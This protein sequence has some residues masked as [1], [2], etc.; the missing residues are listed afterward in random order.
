MLCDQAQRHPFLLFVHPPRT[1]VRSLS[2]LSKECEPCLP[3]PLCRLGAVF[4]VN[5]WHTTEF[6]LTLMKVT[7][8]TADRAGDDTLM[9]AP[10][11]CMLTVLH[12]TLAASLWGR[13]AASPMSH[14]RT[15][16]LRWRNLLSSHQR[17]AG[18]SV[19][20]LRSEARRRLCSFLVSLRRQQKGPM[21]GERDTS[22]ESRVQDPGPT[23]D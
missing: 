22:L 4:S 1:S 16:R 10:P 19:S 14:G 5:A 9:H 3:S 23:Q 15:L 12:L 7:N 17:W 20:H 6:L 13:A 21:E 8:G 2:P 11:P 18:P